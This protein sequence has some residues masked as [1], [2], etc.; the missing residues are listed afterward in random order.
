MAGEQKS[1]TSS[2]EINEIVD[3]KQ[4]KPYV[5]DT[6]VI[7]SMV[8]S[9]S[10]QDNVREPPIQLSDHGHE[11]RPT[12]ATS[13]TMKMECMTMLKLK[14][15]KSPFQP[16]GIALFGKQPNVRVVHF[17]HI[18]ATSFLDYMCLER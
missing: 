11:S 12:P 10:E 15:D 14:F 1:N 16:R 17:I 3:D 4:V 6:N 9:D 7:A 13:T 18:G 2:T 5:N 8:A